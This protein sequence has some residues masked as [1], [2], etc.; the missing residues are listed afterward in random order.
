[1][2]EVSKKCC[3]WKIDEKSILTPISRFDEICSNRIQ[4]SDLQIYLAPVAAEWSSVANERF[5]GEASAIKK[6]GVQ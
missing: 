5:S 4:F 6:Y 1:M 3:Y 2:E